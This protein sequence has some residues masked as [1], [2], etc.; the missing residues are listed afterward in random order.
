MSEQR[1]A[2]LAGMSWVAWAVYFLIV[3][4]LTVWWVWPLFTAWRSRRRRVSPGSSVVVLARPTAGD[5]ADSG[6]KAS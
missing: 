5:R 4:A 1:Q 2:P 6:R 3:V